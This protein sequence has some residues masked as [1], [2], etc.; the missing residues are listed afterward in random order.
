MGCFNLYR[1]RKANLS[2][3][4]NPTIGRQLPIGVLEND[5]LEANIMNFAF[6][7]APYYH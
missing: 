4:S 5:S 2:L 1:R 6:C 7:S 3:S